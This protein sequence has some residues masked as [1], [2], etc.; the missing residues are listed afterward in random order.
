MAR[1]TGFHK[2]SSSYINKIGERNQYYRLNQNTKVKYA[3]KKVTLPKG[4]IVSGTIAESS[5]GIGKTG[6]VLM[7]GLVDISYALKKEWV[8]KSRQR[9]L[10]FTCYIR[11]IGIL[12]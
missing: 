2:V 12:G 4:T 8:L 10:M 5:T 3:G 7:S 1:E 6:K 9:L 11:Q